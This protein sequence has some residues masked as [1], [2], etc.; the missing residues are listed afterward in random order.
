MIPNLKQEALDIAR[1]VIEDPDAVIE[2]SPRNQRLD[3]GTVVTVT[4][5]GKM[6]PEPQRKAKL[7]QT[8][9]SK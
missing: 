3:T 6:G 7:T 8:E 2:V 5:R 9:R 1:R 4:I